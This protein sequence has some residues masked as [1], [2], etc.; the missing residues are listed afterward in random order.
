MRT[1]HEGRVLNAVF[2]L[3]RVATAQDKFPPC[4]SLQGGLV[5][6]FLG[7]KRDISKSREEERAQE[8]LGL[9]VLFQPKSRLDF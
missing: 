9:Q 6:V 4:P 3:E 1:V 2:P 5:I 7:R 8:N